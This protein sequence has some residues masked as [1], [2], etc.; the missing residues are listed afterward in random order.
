MNIVRRLSSTRLSESGF[1][2]QVT[3]A[4]SGPEL[5]LTVSGGRG[6]N[7]IAATPSGALDTGL[8]SSASLSRIALVQVG[9]PDPKSN[10]RTFTLT[11]DVTYRHGSSVLA[12]LS[13]F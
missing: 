5:K 7:V 11:F 12:G 4:P 10:P 2:R 6:P 8:L 1:G 13:A 9:R 3:T